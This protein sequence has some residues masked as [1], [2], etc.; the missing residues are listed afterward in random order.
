MDSVSKILNTGALL[1]SSYKYI[2]E[3][4]NFDNN[5]FFIWLIYRVDKNVPN[6]YVKSECY[7]IF[8]NKYILF[9]KKLIKVTNYE[10][11]Y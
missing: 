1:V 11:E 4:L 8:R 5:I 10:K 3:I 7:G 2:N 9:H 6:P